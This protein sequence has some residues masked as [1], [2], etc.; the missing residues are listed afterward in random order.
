M[1]QR[2]FV[3]FLLAFTLG[4][5]ACR[6]NDQPVPTQ[7]SVEGFQT[8]EFLTANAPP[9]GFD[10]V[11]FALIDANL[12]NIPY[13]RYLVNVSFDGVYSDT[14]AP[15][16][17]NMRM[18]VWK[19][20]LDAAR[21][22]ILRFSDDGVLS[23]AGGNIDA[24]R[25]SNTYF[26]LN[27]NGVCETGEATVAPLANLTAGQVIGGVSTAGPTWRR[28]VINEQQAWQYGFAPTDISFPA[29]QTTV[30]TSALDPIG[31]EMWVAPQFGVVVR[32]TVELN[33]HRVILL[34]GNRE[35]T[36]RVRYQYDV[37]DIGVE[38]NI[39]VPN[40]C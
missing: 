8:A 14:R 11:S 10:E 39:S 27:P 13:A 31:G 5:S 20:D 38:P 30:Q 4:L 19:N 32:Y 34:F 25:I 23:G 7:A 40:G 6:D 22:V 1:M 28:E 33:V 17:S 29:F 26:M 3:I 18:E 16:Q 2:R 15:V 12:E 9:T 36:G 24:V 37:Y 35:V 21:H